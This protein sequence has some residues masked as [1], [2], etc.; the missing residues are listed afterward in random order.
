MNGQGFFPWTMQ[1]GFH[2]HHINHRA[3]SMDSDITEETPGSL[4]ELLEKVDLTHLA[5]ANATAL[6][7]KQAAI[8]SRLA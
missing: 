2:G 6:A 1:H 3:N 8:V 4:R 5:A 7:D